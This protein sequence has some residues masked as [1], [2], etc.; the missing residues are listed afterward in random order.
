LSV[1]DFGLTSIQNNESEG[2]EHTYTYKN[3]KEETKKEEAYKHRI[4]S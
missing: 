3:N 1:A 2:M 4:S